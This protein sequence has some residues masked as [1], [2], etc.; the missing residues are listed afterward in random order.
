MSKTRYVWR[1]KALEMNRPKCDRNGKHQRDRNGNPE[2]HFWRF[3]FV[4]THDAIDA[5]RVAMYRAEN[6]FGHADITIVDL[7]RLC[8][9]EHQPA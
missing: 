7:T 6:E 2:Y 4:A 5:H 9:A 1:C 3:D 8:A